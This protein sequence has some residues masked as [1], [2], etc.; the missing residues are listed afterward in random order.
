MRYDDIV[1]DS[2]IRYER[3]LEVRCSTFS[4]FTH[5]CVMHQRAD[6]QVPLRKQLFDFKI[7]FKTNLS[8]HK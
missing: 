7:E 8:S 6:P 4:M 1:F 5:P 2:L 3:R